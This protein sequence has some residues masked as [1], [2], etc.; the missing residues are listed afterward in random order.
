M[1]GSDALPPLL[2]DASPLGCVSALA[3]DFAS[4]DPQ[5][6]NNVAAIAVSPRKPG[7]IKFDIIM[8]PPLNVEVNLKLE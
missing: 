3:S 7:V 8:V 2:S 5:A 1:V 4:G 6:T